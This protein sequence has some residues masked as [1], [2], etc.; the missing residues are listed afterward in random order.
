[1]L[2]EPDDVLREELLAAILPWIRR[3]IHRNIRRI[4]ANADPANVSSMMHEAAFRAVERLDW[5]RWESWP[6]YL[7]TLVRRAAQE[8][9]RADDYLSR[10]QRVLRTR[11]RLMAEARESHIGRQL[12]GAER[13]SLAREMADGRDDLAALLVMG[14]HPREMAE[15]P[16]E[17]HP[18]VNTEDQ[19]ER[20]IVCEQVRDWLDND[21]PEAIRSKILEWLRSPRSQTLPRRLEANLQ[22]FIARLLAMVD[23]C[24]DAATTPELRSSEPLQVAEP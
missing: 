18:L 24:D 20:M 7:G 9:A 23:E 3:E 10:Q 22:P 1:M 12:S 4:P 15:V 8:A 14:W 19:V 2:G 5:S 13:N 6:V 21:V 11:F 17:M 16:D